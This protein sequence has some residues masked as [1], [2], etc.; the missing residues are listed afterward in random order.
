MAIR[1]KKVE[2]KTIVGGEKAKSFLQPRGVASSVGSRIWPGLTLG[3][4]KLNLGSHV[5]SE[6]R[7][8][9]QGVAGSL[10]GQE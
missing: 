3:G 6:G 8:W 1:S 5:D 4:Q 9:T 2:N 7:M 10:G